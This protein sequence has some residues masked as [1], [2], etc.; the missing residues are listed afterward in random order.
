V[1]DEPFYA[2]GRKPTP[3]GQPPLG[4][5]LFEFVRES[6]HAHFRCELRTHERRGGFEVQFFM[7][8]A[9]FIAQRFGSRDWALEWAELERRAI[10]NVWT[11]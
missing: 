5:R 1:I 4:E 3:P 2:P 7:E 9:L 8:G 10:E 6:D 11:E